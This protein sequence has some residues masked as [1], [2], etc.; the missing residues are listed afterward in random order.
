M[1]EIPY[2][3]LAA[4]LIEASPIVIPDDRRAPEETVDAIMDAL[5]LTQI[6]EHLLLHLTIDHWAVDYEQP[7]TDLDLPRQ[8]R[9]QDQREQAAER[10]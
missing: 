10:C 7:P 3:E 9:R 6:R 1:S 8:L 2:N 5:S 4:L